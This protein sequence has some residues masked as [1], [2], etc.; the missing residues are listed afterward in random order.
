MRLSLILLSSI[1]LGA[2]SVAS[3]G[4]V[5]VET[6]PAPTCLTP[7]API[8]LVGYDDHGT[9]S[10]G[11]DTAHVQSK[12]RRV[13][14]AEDGPSPVGG[15]SVDRETYVSH[16]VFT[17]I[18][19]YWLQLNDSLPS[20]VKPY[21]DL[22]TG[23]YEYST[24]EGFWV[25]VRPYSLV[26]TRPGNSSHSIGVPYPVEHFIE[27]DR[28]YPLFDG[29]DSLAADTDS[30]WRK[31][32]F[33]GSLCTP[34]ERTFSTALCPLRAELTTQ[35]FVALRERLPSVVTNGGVENAAVLAAGSH[36]DLTMPEPAE[37]D[38]GGS[39]AASGAPGSLIPPETSPMAMR[40]QDRSTTARAEAAGASS[41]NPS[42]EAFVVAALTAPA[43]ALFPLLPLVAGVALLLAWS[44]ATRLRREHL[45]RHRAR[46]NLLEFAHQ[47]PGAQLATASATLGLAFKTAE[48]HARV[49][50]KFGLLEVARRGHNLHLFPTGVHGVQDKTAW[51]ALRT[52]ASTAVLE[53]ATRFPGASLTDLARAAGLSKAGTHRCVYDLAA[54]GLVVAESQGRRVSVRPTGRAAA[55]LAIRGTDGARMTESTGR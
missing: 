42:S 21:A 52:G 14:V 12:L 39:D 45:L 36:A 46:H 47:H 48:Y 44:L 40:N 23:T 18:E 4:P 13:S 25:E 33:Y 2:S 38:S 30:V 9:S 49:L 54:S 3:A 55:F 15:V 43:E 7:E 19:G 16:P 53:A 17:T 31:G 1:I 51:I 8:C 29:G 27:R 50:R 11:D 37:A 22:R 6:E 10:L 35:A 24:L 32:T 20:E 26:P 34:E 5:Q 41:P 28:V